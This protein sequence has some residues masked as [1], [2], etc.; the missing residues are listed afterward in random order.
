MA[1][2]TIQEICTKFREALHAEIHW[3]QLANKAAVEAAPYLHAKLQTVELNVN[4]DRVD[5]KSDEELAAEL[6]ESAEVAV[7]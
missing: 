4:D 6:K 1:D 2:L 5:D 3:D 7:D